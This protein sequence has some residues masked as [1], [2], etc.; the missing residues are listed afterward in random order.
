MI[1][2]YIASILLLGSAV[3][4]WG[5][6]KSGL[7]VTNGT[8][9]IFSSWFKVGMALL[10]FLLIVSLIV[11]LGCLILTLFRPGRAVIQRKIVLFILLFTLCALW[12]CGIA[13][14]PEVRKLNE[15]IGSRA[16]S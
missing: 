10:P 15:P 6:Y 7:E 9:V 14:L 4:V 3:L 2:R 13:V 5:V 16:Q 8:G 11:S 1:Y 12:I